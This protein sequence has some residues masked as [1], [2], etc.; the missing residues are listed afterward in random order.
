MSNDLKQAIQKT[1]DDLSNIETLILESNDKQKAQI[2]TYS[3]VQAEGDSV[4]YID[5]NNSI[6]LVKLHSELIKL[7]FK[8]RKAYWNFFIEALK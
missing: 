6:E 8:G 4:H 7:S 3:K 1:I 2:C 5:K